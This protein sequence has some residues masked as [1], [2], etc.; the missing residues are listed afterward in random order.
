MPWITNSIR[1]QINPWNRE[2]KRRRFTYGVTGVILTV[3]PDG[4]GGGRWLGFGRGERRSFFELGKKMAEWEKLGRVGEE[5]RRKRTKVLGP[6]AGRS[7]RPYVAGQTAAPGRSDRAYSAGQTARP[8]A[9]CAQPL[10]KP[11]TPTQ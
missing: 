6:P 7:D 9:G 8:P 2:R 5:G 10:H 4:F 1:T 3:E 11:A